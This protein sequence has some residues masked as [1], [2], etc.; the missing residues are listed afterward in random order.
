MEINQFSDVLGVVPTEDIVEGRFVLLCE[1]SFSYDFGSRE[2]VVG[3]KLP[4][5]TDEG[6]RC[7]FC[8]TWAVSNSSTPMYIPQPVLAQG[9][10]RGGW[11][12]AAN[13][14]ITGATVYL[15]YPGYTEGQTIPSGT[16]S[17]V[18][19]DGT[20]TIPLGGYIA[21][22]SI[23]VP[24]GGVKA[25]I[26]TRAALT[27]IT[28]F[29]ASWSDGSNAIEVPDNVREIM[30]TGWLGR[31]YGAPLLAVEQVYDNLD[32]YNTMIPTDKIVVIGQNVG[33][34]ITYG[35]VKYK[36][37]TDMRPTPPY[38]NLEIFQQFGLCITS[39]EGIYV[40]KIT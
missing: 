18:Y 12:E 28:T 35:D 36:E 25:V 8:L 16:P 38:W 26:G 10:R 22:A 20:F 2:D 29:G 24:T 1:H 30:Q 40:L 32:D 9:A 7:K 17:L 14:P 31:Y 34:F 3:V 15:T 4:D 23:I 19:T 13:T 27:P 21:D 39:A 33:E 5:T 37:W 6:T 11:S